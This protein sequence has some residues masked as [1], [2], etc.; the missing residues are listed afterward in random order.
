MLCLRKITIMA[1]FLSNPIAVLPADS[2]VSFSICGWP[3]LSIR[4]GPLWIAKFI[5][6]F[7]G[8]CED[9]CNCALPE[10]FT[11]NIPFSRSAW[12][13]LFFS[14]ELLIKSPVGLKFSVKNWPL[15]VSR[16]FCSV[17]ISLIVFAVSRV[18]FS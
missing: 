7:S 18:L 11:S 9:F 2:P 17:C 3:V 13:Y 5:V 12:E 4:M 1:P 14:S 16:E 15:N 8:S 10:L 6:W